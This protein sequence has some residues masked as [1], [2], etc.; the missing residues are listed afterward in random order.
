MKISPNTL[1]ERWVDW[2]NI[3]SAMDNVPIENKDIAE[4]A[5]SVKSQANARAAEAEAVKRLI[6]ND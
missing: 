5:A 6:E 1:H 3:A 2:I 4:W